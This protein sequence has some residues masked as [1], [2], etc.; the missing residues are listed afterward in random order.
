MASITRDESGAWRARYRDPN[1]NQHSRNFSRHRDAEL[2]LT[3]IEHAKASGAY[4][5]PLLGRITFAAW[6]EEWRSGVVDLTRSP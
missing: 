1:G 6:A 4:V 5:D 2:F 3:S